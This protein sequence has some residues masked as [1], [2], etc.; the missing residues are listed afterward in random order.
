VT[1][2]YAPRG[3]AELEAAIISPRE[4]T[5]WQLLFAGLATLQDAGALRNELERRAT[6]IQEP[7]PQPMPPGLV[8]DERLTQR[9]ATFIPATVNAGETYWRLVRAEW[10]DVEQSR[11]LH[12]ILVEVVDEQWKRVVGQLVRF[13]WATGSEVKAVE[14]KPND[15]YGVDMPMNAL[16]PSYAC[17]IHALSDRVEGMGLGTLENPHLGEHTSTYLV[18][19]RAIA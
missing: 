17:Q 6:V 13:S 9:G 15:E 11:G 18:F 5:D 7:E 8:W 10:R 3:H 14:A 16:A 4:L 12:H 1:S 2:A 19:Q